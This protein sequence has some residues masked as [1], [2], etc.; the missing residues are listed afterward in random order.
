MCEKA[1]MSKSFRN[2]S[3]TG[4]KT[5]RERNLTMKCKIMFEVLDGSETDEQCPKCG[6]VQTTMIQTTKHVLINE[7]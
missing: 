6:F 2:N 1:V 5:N 4:V 7:T 3:G